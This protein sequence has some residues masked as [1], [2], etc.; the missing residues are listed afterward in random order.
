[1]TAT[2]TDRKAAPRRSALDHGVAM[3][4]AATEYG[5]FLDALRGLA[6]QDWTRPTDC[7]AWDV[8]QMAAHCLGMAEMAASV[9]E[10]LR[11]NREAGRRGGVLIDA[12]TGLQVEE[13][14]DMT[15]EAIVARYA[16]VGPRAARARRRMPAP[17]RL[18]PLPGTETVGGRPERWTFG[19]LIDTILTRD[20]WM[21]RVDIARATGRDLGLTPDHDGVIVGDVVAEWAGRHGAACT[22]SLTGPAGG[23]WTFG[24]GGQVIELDAVEF[25]RTLSRRAPGTGLTDV[26]VPF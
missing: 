11:Q 13:R 19:Y 23:H 26:E 12:L 7:P 6:P 5:R 10:N 21:H 9:R 8:R 25:C 17:V 14:R 24:G 15:P 3:R 1:M 20:P 18:L 22:L 16:E 2:G 4:L